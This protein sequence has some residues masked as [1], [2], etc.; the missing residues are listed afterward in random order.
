[1]G[2][3]GEHVGTVCSGAFDAVAVVNT[4]FSGFVIDVEVL[5]VVVKVNRASAEVSAQES[6]VRCE[7][8]CYIDVAF[9][10]EGDGET[11]LPLVEMRYH[12]RVKLA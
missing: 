10:A 4:A 7:H 9:A 1:M 11:C 2:Y 6:G 12:S 5:E 3:G 8:R